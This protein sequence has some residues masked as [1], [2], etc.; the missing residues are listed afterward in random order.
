MHKIRHRLIIK[1]NLLSHRTC[2]RAE[3]L[4][5]TASAG[6]APVFHKLQP[7]L[8]PPAVAFRHTHQRAG[9]AALLWQSCQATVRQSTVHGQFGEANRIAKIRNMLR[10]TGIPRSAKPC[11]KA[12]TARKERA[13][14]KRLPREAAFVSATEVTTVNH[15]EPFSSGLRHGQAAQNWTEYPPCATQGKPKRLGLQGASV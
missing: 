7:M 5:T 12:L 11:A 13:K 8:A 4:G 14:Q 10:F 15:R 9:A 2:G 6:L 1:L 3:K